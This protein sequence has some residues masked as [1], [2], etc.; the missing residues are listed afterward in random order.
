MGLVEQFVKGVGGNLIKVAPPGWSGTVAAMEEHPEID[1]PYA[2]AWWM[3]GE[4][5][6]PHYAPKPKKAEGMSL[7]E[8]FCAEVNKCP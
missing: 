7:V 6:S 3:E 4:G 5:D 8:K 2:L 1:N